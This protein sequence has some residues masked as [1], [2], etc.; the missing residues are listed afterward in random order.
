M[1]L[2]L[3]ADL[4]GGSGQLTGTLTDGAASY[5]YVGSQATFNAVTA[6]APEAGRYT[7]VLPPN[8]DTTGTSLPQGSGYASIVVS[9]G[10]GAAVTGRLADGTP[11]SAVGHVANDGS[12][13][14][15]CVPSGA[16]RG[17]TLTGELV[18]R[19]TD[20]SDLDGVLTWTRAADAAVQ[21]YPAGFSTALPCIGSHYSEPAPATGLL[22]MDVSP[23]TATAAF[24]AGDL[25]QA[26]SVPVA[27]NRADKVIM[28]VPGAPDV[29]MAINPASGTVAGTFVMP[30][31]KLVRTVRGV[32]LQKQ[33]T[34]YGYFL[35]IDQGGCFSLTPGS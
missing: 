17:S 27:I 34:A 7:L 3:Q 6:K 33:Q 35:G 29:S 21:L 28:T 12:L 16:P 1:V 22:A 9:T 13:S 20:A 15:Y 11:Y 8:P 31:S 24:A 26:I 19:S 25:A 5:G 18:F 32:V 14:L 10:G 30:G 4:T 2:D 23:G